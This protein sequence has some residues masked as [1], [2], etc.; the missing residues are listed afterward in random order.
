MI[1]RV[2]DKLKFK[3]VSKYQPSEDQPQAIEQLIG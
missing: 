2:T 1:N 3:L